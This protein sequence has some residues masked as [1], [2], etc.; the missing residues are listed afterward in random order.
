[1]RITLLKTAFFLALLFGGFLAAQKGLKLGAFVMPTASVLYNADDADLEADAFRYR[2]L[3]GMSSGL[4]LGWNPGDHFGIRLNMV[5]ADGGGRYATRKT[6]VNDVN[7]TTR[8][9]YLKVP[10]MIGLHTNSFKRKTM[11][12]FY[13]GVS[14]NFLVRANSFNDDTDFEAPLPPN[15][16][17]YPDTYAQYEPFTLS[18]LV[19]FGLD[20]F[21]VDDFVLNLHL[22]A[23]YGLGDAENKEATYRQ[24]DGGQTREIPFWQP[25]TRASTSPIS[26]GLLIGLTYTIEG[27]NVG[28]IP[29]GGP[30]PR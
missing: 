1:M 7:Y 26:L 30:V 22:R 28:A 9:H 17:D 21:L 24:T 2:P 20:V 6:F 11:F 15:I 29:T 16:T 13:T 19:D 8:L 5:Y 23:E 12:S 14:P 18:A 27:K 10:L 25:I 4:V 3:P